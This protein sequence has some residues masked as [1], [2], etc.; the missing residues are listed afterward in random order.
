MRSAQVQ[1]YTLPELKLLWE[2]GS[3]F[4]R[5]LL[6]LAL[7]G[8]FG[9]GE[10]ASL[11]LADVSLHQKHPH[12]RE[13]GNPSSQGESW[14]FRMRNKTGVYGEFKLWPETTRAIEWWLVQRECIPVASGVT[15]LL[16]NQ[17]GHRYDTLTKSS[18]PNFQIPNS[19]HRLTKKIRK[20]HPT[21]RSLSFNKLRKT[22]GNLVRSEAH[23]EIAAV[24][25]CHGKPVK[26]DELLDLYTNRPFGKV[27]A[28][29]DK[30]GEK[31]RPLWSGI[32]DPF[33]LGRKETI[34]NISRGTI[35]RVQSMKQQGFK[36]A[37]IAVTLR[38]SI[39]A[40]RHAAKQELDAETAESAS[41]P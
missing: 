28:A 34:S 33:P 30:V 25:L 10:V 38:L 5:L 18:H 12:E 26:A 37:H 3:P 21:F 7:N 41:R 39:A 24:F 1:T 16:V 11:E 19:W 31:L 4:Q 36:V 40:V 14:I 32:V 35:R 17:N 29:L 2:Y 8:G 23:G 15:T 9:R 27:F 22:A 13:V 6:L 20:D